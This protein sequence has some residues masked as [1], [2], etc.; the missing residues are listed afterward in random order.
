MVVGT[1][2]DPATPF[3]WS[4]SL[5]RRLGSG[6]LIS[7]PGAEHTPFGLGNRCVD[8][9]VI[10]HLVDLQAPELH[11][12]GQRE[13]G[14]HQAGAW[15]KL[16]EEIDDSGARGIPHVYGLRAQAPEQILP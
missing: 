5:V 10:R 12:A 11:F 9:A 13:V 4:Q 14:R 1:R 2:R 16:S 7:A 15:Q 3:A 6:V 8:D